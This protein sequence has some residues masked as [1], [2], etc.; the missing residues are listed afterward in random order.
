MN[1]GWATGTGV[2]LL[3]LLAA[4]IAAVA[5]QTNAPSQ[6]AQGAGG[7]SR[8]KYRGEEISRCWEC[9]TPMAGQGQWDKARWMQGERPLLRTGLWTTWDAPQLRCG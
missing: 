3:V 9:H 1:N 7:K 2:F 5:T 4:G 6:T 8:G